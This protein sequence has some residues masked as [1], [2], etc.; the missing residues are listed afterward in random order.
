MKNVLLASALVVSLCGSA[1]AQTYQTYPTYGGGF[2]TQGSNGYIARTSPSYGG[3]FVTQV[4][5][6]FSNGGLPTLNYPGV[7][8][9]PAC[10]QFPH[11]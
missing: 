7:G 2:M 9:C 4:T 8:T 5:P 6:G 1:H 10:T 11:F 3:G